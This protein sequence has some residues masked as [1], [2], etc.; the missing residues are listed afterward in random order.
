V[1]EKEAILCG[2]QKKEKT[3][4]KRENVTQ[5]GSAAMSYDDQHRKKKILT[6]GRVWADVSTGKWWRNVADCWPGAFQMARRSGW[7]FSVATCCD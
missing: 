1:F 7:Q 2:K 5:V 6:P 3:G 4:S